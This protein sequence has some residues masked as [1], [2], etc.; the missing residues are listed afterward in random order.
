MP[1]EKSKALFEKLRSD[2][3]SGKAV[4]MPV[5]VEET[6]PR[7]KRAERASAVPKKTSME[8]MTWVDRV[9]KNLERKEEEA[10]ERN[11]RTEADR[12]DLAKKRT[13]YPLDMK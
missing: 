6:F 7:T 8:H 11:H 4:E 12:E 1:P 13:S 10:D 3:A 5:P 9:A 2:L